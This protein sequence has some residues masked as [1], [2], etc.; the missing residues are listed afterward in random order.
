MKKIISVVIISILL[1]SCN[2][3]NTITLIGDFSSELINYIN[4][5]INSV[6]TFEGMTSN[7]LLKFIEKDAT[8]DK[9]SKISQTIKK[10]KKVIISIGFY[11]YLP[12]LNINPKENIFEVDQELCLRQTEVWQYNIVHIIDELHSMNSK[13]QIFIISP[14]AFYNFDTPEQKLFD[15]FLF[16]LYGILID[17]DLYDFV[18]IISTYKLTYKEVIDVI[19]VLI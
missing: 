7:E 6:F 17:I 10:S 2:I 15:S 11:D 19:G 18:E 8:S 4:K 14:F 9:G 3:N 13:I 1:N 12:Y 5:N 16:S